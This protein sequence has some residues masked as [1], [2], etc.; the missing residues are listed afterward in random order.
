[1]GEGTLIVIVNNKHA[2]LISEGH[3]NNKNKAIQMA[4]QKH[5]EIIL[6]EKFEWKKIKDDYEVRANLEK[7]ID[8]DFDWGKEIDINNLQAY[9]SNN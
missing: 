8:P 3:D 7:D 1:M 6:G 9:W 4:I 5:T 2:Y